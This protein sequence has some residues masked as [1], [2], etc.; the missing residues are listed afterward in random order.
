[1]FDFYFGDNQSISE[2]ESDYLIF[3]KHMLPRWCNSIPDSE[4]LAI[5][6]LLE[7]APM[8]RKGR[9]IAETGVGA[10]TLVLLNHAIK[11][12]IILY[13]WDINAN[14]GAYLR[15]VIK[16]IFFKDYTV[17]KTSISILGIICFFSGMFYNKQ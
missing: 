1:M 2:N 7:S 13:S 17:I 11:N 15:S 8:A 12:D 3:I 10:S 5:H 6:E 4:F 16:L 14:K 9:V